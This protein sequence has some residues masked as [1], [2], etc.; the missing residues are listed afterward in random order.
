MYGEWKEVKIIIPRELT[1]LAEG[2]LY[3]LDIK[4]LSVEDPQ[5][6]LDR[7]AGPTTWDFA[8]INIFRDGP[9][10]AV[11]KCYI[12]DNEEASEKI[13]YIEDSFMNL[14]EE[15]CPGKDYSVETIKI[16]EE[17]WANSWKKH[18]KPIRIGKN[19]VIRPTW[20]KYDKK[21]GDIIIEM[22]PGMAFGTGTHETTR[23]CMEA[24][25][26][27][28]KPGDMV[29]D[30]GT[31]S[32]ILA[33]TSSLLGAGEVTAV[34]L[35]PVAVD[36]AKINMKLNKAENMK[37]LYGNM[38]EVV[39]GKADIVVANIIADI[40]IL[41]ADD[42]ERVLKPGGIFISSGI[43][44]FRLPEVREKLISKNFEIME[45]KN[46]NDWRC[47]VARLKE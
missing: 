15:N 24:L 42:I 16:H 1:D 9:D 7:K 28:V 27:Y 22:D 18:Y 12:P 36:S 2:I 37:V 43:I 19:L 6:I 40:I 38:T 45:E 41:I 25:E 20:E 39:E 17:D 44:D 31:G 47:V 29:T 30:V 4:G 35:D 13:K 8:D 23:M 21:D 11:I 34:D 46:E 14:M 10:K 5:D 26:E 32:G 3:S 33:V